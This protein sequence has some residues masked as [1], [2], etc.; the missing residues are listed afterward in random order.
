MWL[1]QCA[2]PFHQKDEII[3]MCTT[4]LQTQD[5]Y[6]YQSH[7]QVS[8]DEKSGIQCRDM[9][10]WWRREGMA[11]DVFTVLISWCY[12]TSLGC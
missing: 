1:Q 9:G 12:Q 11:Q 5:W 8:L 7:K 6:I 3:T 2:I 10:W 4:M